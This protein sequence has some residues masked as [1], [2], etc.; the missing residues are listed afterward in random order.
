[1]D[2]AGFVRINL[3]GREPRGI[4]RSGREYDDLCD[5]LREALS[6]VRDVDTDEPIA[7]RV[8]RI[9]EIAPS[10][11][12]Y[13]NVLPDLVVTWRARSAIA[14][15]GIYRAGYGERRW[16]GGALPS[17]RSGNHRDHGW[18]M[19]VGRGIEGGGRADG[20]HIVDL[21]PTVFDWL[22]AEVGSDFHGK[23]I[24]ALCGGHRLR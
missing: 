13:R 11:A 17:L 20:H 3:G 8:Y 12:P 23:P 18:F 16:N 6:Q 2:H 9:D 22:G 4:V 15:R 21:V 19:A 14:S 5:E 10:A 7:E 24:P 1:M